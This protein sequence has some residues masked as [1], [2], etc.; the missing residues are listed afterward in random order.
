MAS[1]ASWRSEVARRASDMQAAQRGLVRPDGGQATTAFDHQPRAQP[2]I[3]R[4][5]LRR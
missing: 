1:A 2:E 5:Q 4:K 3:N